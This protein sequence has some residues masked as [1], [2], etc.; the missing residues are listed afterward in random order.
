MNKHVTVKAV[1]KLVCYVTL[2]AAS[3]AIEQ[4]CYVAESPH[5]CALGLLVTKMRMVDQDGVR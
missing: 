2:R 3:L 5:I 4:E 1:E